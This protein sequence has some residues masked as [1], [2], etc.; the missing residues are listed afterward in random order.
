MENDYLNLT[1]AAIAIGI[2]RMTISR[3]VKKGKLKPITI[4]NYPLL[5]PAQIYPYLSKH[6]SNCYHEKHENG[7]RVCTCREISD[8]EGG[9]KD[10]VWK[11]N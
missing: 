10:W 7:T 8:I 5:T 6:C 2:S 11:W 1:E 9:C 3:W 4:G